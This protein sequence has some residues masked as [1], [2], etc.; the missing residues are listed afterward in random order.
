MLWRTVCATDARLGTTW[1]RW[2][3]PRHQ[4]T[5]ASVV[6]RFPK[7]IPT[8]HVP[9]DLLISFK[10]IIVY[11]YIY[12]I[13]ILIYNMIYIYNIIIQYITYFTDIYWQ[14]SP[15]LN[16]FKMQSCRGPLYE[17]L[18][19]F[20]PF[21]QTHITSRV[22]ST[23]RLLMWVSSTTESTDNLDNTSHVPNFWRDCDCTLQSTAVPR[24][25]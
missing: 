3:E 6:R 13:Y 21:F 14:R 16:P 19:P 1:F 2:N 10:V 4:M 15:I 8:D 25:F 9:L 18:Q 12:T 5:L 17:L 7:R 23:L 24:C 22:C 11:V 20:L